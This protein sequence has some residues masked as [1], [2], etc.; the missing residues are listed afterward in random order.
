MTRTVAMNPQ[1]LRYISQPDRFDAAMDRLDTA[2]ILRGLNREYQ[3]IARRTNILTELQA[4]L[5]AREQALVIR[6]R[7][8]ATQELAL[9]SSVVLA[10][11]FVWDHR[12]REL[13]HD[14][15]HVYLSPRE[16]QIVTLLAMQPGVWVCQQQII[17]LVWGEGPWSENILR[18]PIARL[19]QR[20]RVV[21]KVWTR[22]NRFGAGELIEPRS[23]AHGEYRLRTPAC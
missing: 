1:P 11:G 16:G 2:D 17:D 9:P 10:D 18:A 14:S 12:N 20:C 15:T 13:Y 6:E 8:L 7:I 3:E 19:H 23:T 22:Q 21:C 5:E 4:R